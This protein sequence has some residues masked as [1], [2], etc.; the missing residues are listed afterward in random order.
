MIREVLESDEQGNPA[1]VVYRETPAEA[2]VRRAEVAE[3]A[4]R[5]RDVA[6]S[7]LVPYR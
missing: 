2:A 7:L 5:A 4:A 1:V 6:R 3:Q